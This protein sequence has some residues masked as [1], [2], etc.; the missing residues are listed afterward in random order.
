MQGG[1]GPFGRDQF[2][3][4]PLLDDFALAQHDDPIR[5]AHR[6]KPVGDNEGG[7]PPAQLFQTFHDEGFGFGV[8]RGSRLI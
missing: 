6:R 7:S 8:H 1:K 2:V 4:G 3:E 5:L